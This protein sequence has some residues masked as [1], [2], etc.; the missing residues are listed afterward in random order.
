MIKNNLIGLTNM[1]RRNLQIPL[2][3]LLNTLDKKTSNSSPSTQGS[4]SPRPCEQEN[5][6][7]YSIRKDKEKSQLCKKYLEFGFCP[8]EKKCKFAHGLH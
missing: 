1:L 2:H 4:D 3:E 7:Q 5:H 8:Y 6:C